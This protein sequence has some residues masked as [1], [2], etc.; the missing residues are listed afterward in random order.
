[1]LLAKQLEDEVLR[2]GRALTL[3]DACAMA[4]G[5]QALVL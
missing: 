5:Q 2:D 3:D 1:M 4:L